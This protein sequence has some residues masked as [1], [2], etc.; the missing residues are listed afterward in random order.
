MDNEW[1]SLLAEVEKKRVTL[2]L[3]DLSAISEEL[4][5]QLSEEV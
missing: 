2:L 5:H 1:E 3:T 4:G